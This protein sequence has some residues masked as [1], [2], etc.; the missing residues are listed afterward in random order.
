MNMC[1]TRN[2]RKTVDFTKDRFTATSLHL[3][4]IS[5][6]YHFQPASRIV[7]G[8]LSDWNQPKDYEGSEVDL[9][10]LKTFDSPLS[11][12]PTGSQQASFQGIF[13]GKPSDTKILQ[14]FMEKIPSKI[15]L[16]FGLIPVRQTAGHRLF[17]TP[18]AAINTCV[19]AK[20]TKPQEK[21]NG[22]KV[23]TS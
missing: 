13:S 15:Q 1:C 6:S 17:Q 9:N 21:T 10:P 12:V 8:S 14:S 5:T 19:S 7:P 11:A 22:T 16:A 20:S 3:G 2:N 4:I 23:K 18:F